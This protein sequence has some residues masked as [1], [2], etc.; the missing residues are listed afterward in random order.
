MSHELPPLGR[1]EYR[2]YGRHVALAEIGEGG[3]RLLKASS[4]L[5]VGAGGLGSP[6]ALYLAAAGVGRLTLCD[7]DVVDASNLQ[8]QVLFGTADL[9]R[10]KAEAG[11]E[12]L[13]ALNP[14]VEVAVVA[15]RVSTANAQ[16]LVD[17]HDVVVDGS[18]NFG[19]R[20]LVADA[21]VLGGKPYVYGSIHRF[22]GQAS[23]FH[24]PRGPCYRCL[25]PEPPPEGLVPNCAQAGVLGALAGLVGSI[26]A[27]EAVKILLGAGTPL[28][29]RLL[30]I[31]LL[32]ATFREVRLRRDPA[33]PACGERPTITR[34]VEVAG[35]GCAATPS[36]AAKELAALVGSPG[37]PVLV[38]VREAWEFAAGSLPGAVN[39][40]LGEVPVGGV[41]LPR[42]RDV[43]VFC[44]VGPRGDRAAELLRAAGIDRVRN[45]RGGLAA[46]RDDVDP[47][48]VVA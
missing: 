45:L 44:S 39:V 31:D 9:G 2:R 16:A 4:V 10:P 35:P 15:D 14:H 26:Q 28:V 17:A 33:C 13:R 19:T 41:L 30:L 43:V 36:I 34:A 48:T 6:A 20:Y 22:E 47:A 24:T 11:A 25:F 38:D 21:C 12:R 23:V 40:P 42:D 7:F 37:A 46:W 1:D 32:G 18:D 8:R 29:G 27:A 3:Q 5:V